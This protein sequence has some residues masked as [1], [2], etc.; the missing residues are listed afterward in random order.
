VRL[1]QHLTGWEVVVLSETK[2]AEM[3][4]QAR[5]ELSRIEALSN[6]GVD[7]LIR[8]GFHSLAEVADAEAYDLA[9]VLGCEEEDAEAV[10][11]SAE[12]ALESLILEEAQERKAA[13]DLPPEA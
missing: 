4:A 2:H 7:L 10:I 11:Q 6:E 8:H 12:A 9:G 1:A 5:T 13:A 3:S